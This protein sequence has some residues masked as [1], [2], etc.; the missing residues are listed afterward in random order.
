MSKLFVHIFLVGVFCILIISLIWTN[1]DT[2]ENLGEKLKHSQ[3]NILHKFKG[4]EHYH[5]LSSHENLET[6]LRNK[7]ECIILFMAP[8]CKVCKKIENDNILR[9]VSKKK[10]V[11]KINDRHPDTPLYMNTFD[12]QTFPGILIYKNKK[13]SKFDKKIS[14]ENLLQ[15]LK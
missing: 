15:E 5:S 3:D 6:K 7:K 2:F 1:S 9:M 8:W 13:L 4:S 14:I 10:C 11:I 12:I